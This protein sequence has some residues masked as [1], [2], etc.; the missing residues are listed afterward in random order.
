MGLENSLENMT[1]NGVTLG[2]GMWKPNNPIIYCFKQL[3]IQ[4][5][6][7]TNNILVDHD[8]VGEEFLQNLGFPVEVTQFVRGHVQAKRYL[9]FKD[10]AYHDRLTEASKGLNAF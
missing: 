2:T 10:P 7:S 5:R 9:V 8:K 1:H 3:I 6:K 4:L